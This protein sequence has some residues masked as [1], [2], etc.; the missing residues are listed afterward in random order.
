ME[1]CTT[2]GLGFERF[3][4][5]SGSRFVDVDAHKL[6]TLLEDVNKVQNQ[7]E[8]QPPL[9]SFHLQ[10][11]SQISARKIHLVWK[12]WARFRRVMR[13]ASSDEARVERW[14]K[15][16]PIFLRDKS[17]HTRKK[18]IMNTKKRCSLEFVNSILKLPGCIFITTCEK[19]NLP[20]PSQAWRKQC[21]RWA[22]M[23]ANKKYQCKIAV[24]S[25][26]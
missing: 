14:D 11:V 19:L 17:K 21:P 9:P 25:S 24:A 16:Y 4:H 23:D 22:C 15:V 20:V 2:K 26:F 12:G 3:P 10:P 5:S 1:N 6:G 13:P 18:Q 8:N 7:R